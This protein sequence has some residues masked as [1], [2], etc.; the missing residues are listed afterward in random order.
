MAAGTVVAIMA[1]LAT[2]MLLARLKRRSQQ[3]LIQVSCSNLYTRHL[4]AI[5]LETA[6]VWA[7][8]LQSTKST[9]FLGYSPNIWKVIVVTGFRVGILICV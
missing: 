3:N 2:V 1:S 6:T 4:R 5:H 8:L 7:L 9:H